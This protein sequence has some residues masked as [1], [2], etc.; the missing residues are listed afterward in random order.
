M[1]ICNTK[2]L[3]S[4]L[5]LKFNLKNIRKKKIKIDHI[6]KALV[7]HCL[8]G[9]K[10]VFNGLNDD[11]IKKLFIDFW[12]GTHPLIRQPEKSRIKK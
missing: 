6:E 5:N 3:A 4:N 7:W 10:R 8:T 1:V 9:D 2:K 11:Q 12:N